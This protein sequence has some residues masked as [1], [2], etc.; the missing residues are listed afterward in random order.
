MREWPSSVCRMERLKAKGGLLLLVCVPVRVRKEAQLY[1]SNASNSPC[2]RAVVFHGQA[3]SEP[4]ALYD[5]L[6]LISSITQPTSKPQHCSR[7]PVSYNTSCTRARVCTKP[8]TCPR[9]A[10][11]FLS[12][13]SRP[14]SLP[15]SLSSSLPSSLISFLPPSLLPSLPLLLPPAL[16][17]SLPV[18]FLPSSL[19]HFCVYVHC[20]PRCAPLATLLAGLQLER[21]WYKR[22][23]LGSWLTSE[24]RS[25]RCSRC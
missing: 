12:L 22:R 16:S 8:F 9:S 18:A 14:P 2:S 23:P 11:V 10:H 24:H 21:P 3:S 6:V 15:L 1:H 20:L 5:L 25:Q 17:C 19:A 13:P 4:L 7:N